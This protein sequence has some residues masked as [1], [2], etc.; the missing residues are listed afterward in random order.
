[1]EHLSKGILRAKHN[2]YVNKDG[3]TRYD[4]TE[5]PITHFKPREIKT[6]VERLKKLGYLIDVNGT[7]QKYH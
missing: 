4:G 1:M 7:S 3:T 2:I 6:S 5:M